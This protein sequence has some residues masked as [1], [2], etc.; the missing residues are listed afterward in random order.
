MPLSASDFAFTWSSVHREFPPSTTRSPSPSSS[1]ELERSW[2]ESGSPAGTITQTTLG[3]GQLVDHVLQ[4]LGVAE[5]RVAVVARRRCGRRCAAACACCRPSCP[6]QRVRGACCVLP[7]SC[8][9]VGVSPASATASA[10]SGKSRSGSPS[11]SA[12]RGECRRPAGFGHR[13][14]GV[15]PWDGARPSSRYDGL[16]PM[17]IAVAGQRRLEGLRGLRLLA[18]ARLERERRVA[19]RQPDR[20]VATGDQRDPLDRLDQ[21]R[22]LDPRCDV[23]GVRE[24]LAYVRESTLDQPGGGQPTAA[25][26]SRRRTRSVR[27][28][29]HCPRRARSSARCRRSGTWR[30]RTGLG[31]APARWTRGRAGRGSRSAPADSAGTGRSRAATA[32]AVDLDLDPGE[33]RQHVVTARRRDRLGDCG[34]EAV[35]VDGADRGGHLRQRGI[36]LDRHRLQA[37]A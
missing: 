19:E 35:G 2:C 23:G 4:A 5:L 32:A 22:H 7:V 10:G 26:R 31:P 9:F 20:G 3:F 34:H 11:G 6:A 30:C 15:L 13:D 21:G 29:R 14:V 16:K 33:H 8:R 27:H 12:Q 25:R 37:E 17:V 24:E 18:V 28:P 36:V 1:L